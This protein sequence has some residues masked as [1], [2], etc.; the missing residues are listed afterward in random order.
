MHPDVGEALASIFEGIEKLKACC[1]DGRRFTI[2]G[3]LVG[4]IGELLAARDFD[5]LLDAKSGKTHDGC[6][7]RDPTRL[8]QVKATF[9]DHLTFGREPVLYLGLKLYRDGRYDVV[10]NGPGSVVSRAFGHRKDIG[11]KLLS[12]PVSRLRQLNEGVDDAD[13]VPPRTKP[14]V[15]T[16]S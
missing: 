4:D 10:F 8:V 13:R 1:R 7:A 6:L 12:F 14:S 11:R 2:D 16:G 9:Q 3:R 15:N 5:I